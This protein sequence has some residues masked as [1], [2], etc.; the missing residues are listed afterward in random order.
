MKIITIILLLATSNVYSEIPSVNSMGFA[1]KHQI[2]KDLFK[3]AKFIQGNKMSL[4]PKKTAYELYFSGLYKGQ[5]AV[6]QINCKAVNATGD[7][8]YCK[9][10]G[11]KAS[12]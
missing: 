12:N 6:M 10:V 8:E 11:V 3:D 2:N 4:G 1:A 5:K 9:P 7:I